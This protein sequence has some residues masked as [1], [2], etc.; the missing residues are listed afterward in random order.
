MFIRIRSLWMLLEIKLG[1]RI[2]IVVNRDAAWKEN[3]S[4]YYLFGC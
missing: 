1:Q 2:M 4:S 3:R